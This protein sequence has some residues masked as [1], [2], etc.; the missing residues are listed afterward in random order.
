MNKLDYYLYIQNLKKTKRYE[1]IPELHE[2]V[3]D[4]S[5][6]LCFFA[7][8]LAKQFDLH[9]NLE[10]VLQ[11]ALY[12]DVPEIGMSFDYDAK[13]TSKNPSKKQKKIQEEK[14]KINNLVSKFGNQIMKN[15]L[16]DYE[17]QQSL[18]A[19]F[20]KLVDKLEAMVYTLSNDCAGMKDDDLIFI[21]NYADPYIHNFE[22]LKPFLKD[23]KSQFAPYLQKFGL[24]F[25]D[26]NT[27]N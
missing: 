15:S 3:T 19:K 22:E 11:I 6:M 9:L 12:H 13:S 21:I 10:K 17:I 18:E 2:S 23:L 5:Y 7:L 27:Q 24:N 8:D 25:E 4:H 20:V 26:L 16:Q 1:T 14:E